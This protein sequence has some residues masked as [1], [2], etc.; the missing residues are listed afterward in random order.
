MHITSDMT[1]P[2]ADMTTTLTPDPEGATPPAPAME[3]LG[4]E[5]PP[6]EAIPIFDPA[7]EKASHD[8]YKSNSVAQQWPSAKTLID[9]QN[10]LI[11]AMLTR[12]NQLIKLATSPEEEG[13][14]L[15]NQASL[16]L[17]IEVEFQALVSSRSRYLDLGPTFFAGQRSR[18]PTQID[19]RAQGAV[20]CWSLKRYRR[21][22]R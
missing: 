15:E 1:T 8:N 9:R 3:K 5:S 10:R 22:R 19:A 18:G 13:A 7:N 11:A 12:F 2:A 6:N 17:Q 4:F 21:R 20:A 16:S 14:T